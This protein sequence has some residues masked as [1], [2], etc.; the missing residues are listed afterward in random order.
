MCIHFWHVL[1][2]MGIV[3]EG[4]GHCIQASLPE[5]RVVE[6][7]PD[8]VLEDLRYSQ[9]PKASVDTA[10]NDLTRAGTDADLMRAGRSV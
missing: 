6:S 5:H 9:R 8:N 10:L 2:Y 4:L 1:H 3:S 7:K